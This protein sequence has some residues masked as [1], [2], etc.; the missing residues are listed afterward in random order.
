MH[1]H[2]FDLELCSNK[3]F[4]PACAEEENDVIDYILTGFWF[5]DPSKDHLY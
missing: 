3:Y 1:Q 4:F 5:I 2:I